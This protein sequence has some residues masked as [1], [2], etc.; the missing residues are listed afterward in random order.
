MDSCSDRLPL[1]G[2]GGQ[3]GDTRSTF[4]PPPKKFGVQPFKLAIGKI[5]GI[6]IVGTR[7]RYFFLGTDK[8]IREKRNFLVN[9]SVPKI[10]NEKMGLA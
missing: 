5:G 2:A 4:R 7:A 9:R 8:E 3:T 10:F 1:E 6:K